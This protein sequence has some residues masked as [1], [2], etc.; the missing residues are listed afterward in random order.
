MSAHHPTIHHSDPRGIASLK[1]RLLLALSLLAILLAFSAGATASPARI[2]TPAVSGRW[3]QV[4]KGNGTV[5]ALIGIDAQR[6]IGVGAQGMII[7]STDG[8]VSWRYQSPAPDKDLFDLSLVGTSAWAVGQGGVVF[9]SEDRGGSWRQLPSGMTT[10]LNGVHFL[11][12]GNGWVVGDGG[13]IARTTNGGGAWT[14]QTSGVT[15]PLRAVRMFADGLHGV[16]VGDSGTFLTTTN[17]GA[18]WSVRAGLANA[19]L[20]DVHVQGNEAWVVGNGGVLLYSNNQGATWNPKPVPVFDISEIEFAPGQNQI[21]WASGVSVNAGVEDERIYR[22]TDGGNTWTPVTTIAGSDFDLQ[23]ARHTQNPV[24]GLDGLAVT[25]LG[26]GDSSHAWVGGGA[27]L[28]NEGNY[29][30]APADKITR[31]SWFVWRTADGVNWQHL[32]GG[33]YPWYY[34]IAA[35]TTQIA[36]LTGQDMVVLK[37]T[38]GGV[39]WRELANELRA[40]P[41]MADA[42]ANHRGDILHGVSCAP[43]DPNDCHVSGRRGILAH[44][45]D[46]GATWTSES[47][48][49]YGGSLYDLNMTA[50]TSGVALGRGAHFYSGNGRQWVQGTGSATGL[51][52]DM[53]SP[54]EGGRASKRT[55]YFA[56]TTNGGRAWQTYTMSS[57]YTAW[58]TD[59]F[60]AYD[61]NGDGDLDHGWLVGCV[62]AAGDIDAQPC[63]A[64]AILH[65]P[66]L[67]AGASAWQDYVVTG[68]SLQLERIEMLDLTTGWMVGEKG[69]ILFTEDGG[70]TWTRQ[71]VP[72]DGWLNALDVVNSSL[73]YVAGED[74]VVFRYGASYSQ[75]LSAP[76]QQNTVADGDLS[77]WTPASAVTIAADQADTVIGVTPDAADLSARLRV[78]WWEDRLFL[79][80][81]VSDDAVTAQ[82][83]IE[84][85]VDGLNDDNGGGSDDHLFRFFTDGWVTTDGVALVGAVQTGG[86]GYRIE[87]EIPA[88]ALG[89]GFVPGRTV[90]LNVGLFDDDG[91]GEESAILWTAPTMTGDPGRF[92][93]ITLQ[94]FGG[95]SRTFA[96]LPTGNLALD[97]SLSDWSGEEALALS[98]ASADTA[99]GEPAAAVDLSADVYSRW[100]PNYLF[101]GVRVRDD[102][103]LPG[104]AVHLAFDGDKDGRGGGPTDWVM[105][106]GADG[107]VS[108]GFNALAFT[109]PTADG[110]DVEVAVPSSMLGGAL[111]YNR[112]LGFNIGVADDDGGDAR[113]RNLAR[114][115]RRQPRRGLCRPGSDAA[116]GSLPDP[117]AW[118]ERLHRRRRHL[119]RP[120]AT[121][122]QPRRRPGAGMARRAQ[123]RP[124]QERTC[125]LRPGR[126]A[127]WRQ[128]RQRYP[129]LQRRLRWRAGLS[130]G[131]RS[132]RPAFVGCER[133][134]LEE[135]R[136]RRPLGSRWRPRRLRP[137]QY[138]HSQQGPD[139][140]GLDQLQRYRRCDRICQRFRLQPRLVD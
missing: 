78:R 40:G 64:A 106:I 1:R 94:P 111:A 126:I 134:H 50:K 68:D 103:I 81:D 66:D 11:D 25:A 7:G 76:P 42:V 92:A 31:S 108:G 18:N 139:G 51:D 117:T 93:S 121:R 28:K 87:V 85:A 95:T 116:S 119:P 20:R 27:D 57:R 123:Q 12:S 80:L 70:V 97:G 69:R 112:A 102:A 14:P 65:N 63:Q 77:D 37:T 8:G 122:R 114:V 56:F 67:K 120:L 9:F 49:N 10:N 61:A 115:G 48:A 138:A 32:I 101:L 133:R 127:A 100:W 79:A 110:Y 24:L 2:E 118:P 84:L 36:Y 98:A 16:A 75:N 58:Q 54:E 13:L 107:S 23:R 39:T 53:V 46:G 4:W 105:R 33:F 88:S 43:G 35:V 128:H 129:L 45:T 89:S 83:H 6:V 137:R 82:D 131:Q 22:T 52:L 5:H 19:H 99:Q 72:A 109:S 21:G 86:G 17:G 96:S 104:D 136:C 140:S 30:D 135:R 59:G 91:R 113:A 41:G 71:S 132:P 3:Q 38:D 124:G 55:D 60:D 90:G 44:T 47:P 74:G 15:A 62:K 130:V 125:A 73:A 26:V 29:Y 34:N